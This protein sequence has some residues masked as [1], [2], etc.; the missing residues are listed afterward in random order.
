MQQMSHQAAF[1][2]MQIAPLM[3]QS[4]F[5]GIH[6]PFLLGLLVF[7]LIAKQKDITLQR[8]EQLTFTVCVN[9]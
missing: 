5:K 8:Y 9:T 7:F 3:L 2:A 1:W 6:T 4:L